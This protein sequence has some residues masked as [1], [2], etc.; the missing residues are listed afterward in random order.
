MTTKNSTVENMQLC[1]TPLPTRKGA[2]RVPLYSTRHLAPLY[3][4]LMTD[5]IF[6]G[7]PLQRPFPRCQRPFQ[8]LQ[9]SDAN[10]TVFST[11]PDDYPQRVNVV[12]ARRSRSEACLLTIYGGI[13][14]VF[15]RYH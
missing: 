7:I 8:S 3:V 10:R 12:N 9:T 6:L 15:Y 1:L 2:E 5:T 11:F 14:I 13:K 4:D